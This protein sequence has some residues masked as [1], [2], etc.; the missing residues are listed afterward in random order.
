MFLAAAIAPDGFQFPTN[1]S[2]FGMDVPV[3]ALAATS[4]TDG[5]ACCWDADQFDEPHPVEMIKAS[6]PADTI[7]ERYT[8]TRWVRWKCT[9]PPRR[10]PQPGQG[11]TGACMGFDL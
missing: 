6:K 10:R 3:T 8:R 5:G 2:P 1:S 9:K 11:P 7:R 4:A